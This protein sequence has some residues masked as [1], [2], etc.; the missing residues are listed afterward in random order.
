MWAICVP[1]ARSRRTALEQRMA[2]LPKAVSLP[3]LI[4][5][6]AGASIVSII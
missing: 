2:Q 5:T 6:L 4:F 1:V 3:I